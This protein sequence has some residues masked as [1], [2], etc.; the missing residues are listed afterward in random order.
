MTTYPFSPD[1][2]TP[3]G[4]TLE[5]KLEEL[6]MSQAELAR[7]TGLS[8]KHINQIVRG[9]VPIT[10]EVAWRLERATGVP[11]RLWNNLESRY[12][13]HQ[14]RLA[15]EADLAEQVDLLELLPIASMVKLGILTKRADRVARLRE[16]FAFLGVSDRPAWNATLDNYRVAFR[17]SQAHDS[18]DGAIAVWLRMGELAASHIDC[19]PWSPDRFRE[20]LIAVRALTRETDPA[21]WHPALV[22]ECAA[23]GVC[24]VVT[25][26]IEGART[27]GATRWL[28][29]GRPLIQLSLRFRWSDIFWFTFF[30]EA[31]HV[32]DGS[33]R[34]IYIEQ[35]NG[36][37]EDR[38]EEERQADEFASNFL[39]P[40]QRTR[41]LRTIGSLDDVELFAADLG[42]HPGIVVGRLQ[43][44]DIWPHTH[45]NGL[46]QR[47]TLSASA[48]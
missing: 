23:A 1:Y 11:D 3:P 20:A 34:A 9:K 10:T 36:D 13:E 21:V 47:L 44:E 24:V 42:I 40:K 14:A 46:R 15:E 8:T 25:H 5:E 33:K 48:A 27:H 6:S 29:S 35:P 39:I 43:H 12:Q 38:S 30:H 45:G 37:G 7:R 41:V 22:A 28:R 19:A 32:L 18:N 4:W 2:A 31:K 17:K 16:A 26:E